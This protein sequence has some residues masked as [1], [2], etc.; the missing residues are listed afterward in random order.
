MSAVEVIG[1]AHAGGAGLEARELC[2]A[3]TRFGP[4]PNRAVGIQC[5]TQ[6]RRPS[7]ADLIGSPG[8]M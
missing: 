1:L 4:S 7:A 6:G 2:S 3:R 5:C 8:T